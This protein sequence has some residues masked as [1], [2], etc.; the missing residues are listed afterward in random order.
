MSLSPAVL[1]RLGGEGPPVLFVHGFAADRFGWAA[2]A[3]AL[4]G[5]RSVWAAD[6]PGHGSA[7]NGVGEGSPA[8]LAEGLMAA[9]A[10][11]P[12]PVP[13]VAHSLGALVVLALARARPG[14]LGRM[15]LIAPAGLGRG[16]DAGIL[17]A[18]P[19]LDSQEAAE[20][21]LS[22]MVERPRMVP[23]MA[24]HVLSGLADPARRAAL[25]RI[26][27]ALPGAALSG[28][29]GSGAG[30]EVGVEVGAEVG[31]VLWGSADRIVPAPGGMV[32][33]VMPEIIAGAGHLPHAEAAGAVNRRLAAVLA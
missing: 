2:N 19:A 25:A 16:I 13:V 28:A 23:P 10:D 14:M 5:S 1:H 29:D 20:R 17:A 30:A 9:V 27:A 21:V 7:G 15:V 18:I 3:H 22:Q 24:A 8:A 33:G 6:L 26:A 11:L 31:A 4:M 32:L 12:Q